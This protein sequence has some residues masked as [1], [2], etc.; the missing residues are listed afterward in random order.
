MLSGSLA[1]FN[2]IDP[3]AVRGCQIILVLDTLAEIAQI[4]LV[5][6]NLVQ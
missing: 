1:N 6:L 5:D 2:D 4:L 3:A